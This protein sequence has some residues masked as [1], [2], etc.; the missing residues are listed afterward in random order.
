MVKEKYGKQL[1]AIEKCKIVTKLERELNNK[2][3]TL[4]FCLV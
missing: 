2:E 4:Y 1:T 3:L